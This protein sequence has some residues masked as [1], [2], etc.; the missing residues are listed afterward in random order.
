MLGEMTPDSAREFIDSAT[1][2]WHQRFELAPGVLTPG[3]SNV[4]FLLDRAGVPADLS[5]RTVLDVGTTNGGAAFEAERRGASR[6][7]AVDI[8]PPDRFGFTELA[9][10]CR[11]RVEFLQASV[12]ELPDLLREQFDLVLFFG[13]LYHLRHPLLALDR[14]RE[15]TGGDIG[16]ESAIC[17]AEDLLLSKA[18]YVRFYRG[19]ELGNDPSNWFAPSGKTLQDWMNSSGFAVQSYMAWPGDAPTRAMVRATRTSAAPEYTTLSYEQPITL[20]RVQNG[21]RA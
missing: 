21:G 16:V 9:E 1:F 5:G 8:Y 20:V 6:V 11:S 19:G 7:V 10:A 18:S 12:Y 14:L 15:L 3:T 17:D 2:L 4:A 13:V